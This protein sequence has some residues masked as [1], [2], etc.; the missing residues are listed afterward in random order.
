MADQPCWPLPL[1]VAGVYRAGEC[2][3][4]ADGDVDRDDKAVV[5]IVEGQHRDASR[6]ALEAA[7]AEMTT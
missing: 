5:D 7:W 3:E 1:T 4:T 6:C 2:D